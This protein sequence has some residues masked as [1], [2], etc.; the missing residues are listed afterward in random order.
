MGRVQLIDTESSSYSFNF[1]AVAPNQGLVASQTTFSYGL[2]GFEDLAY[3]LGFDRVG[4]YYS[5]LFD[6]L[7]G[8]GCGRRQT[9]R[10]RLRPYPG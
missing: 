10:H 6:S 3:W 2:A 5:F 8:A 9:K 1:K 7:N 4:L